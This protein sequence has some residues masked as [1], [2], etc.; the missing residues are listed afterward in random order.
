MAVW[1]LSE[2]YV[3][4]DN[5]ER[6]GQRVETVGGDQSIVGNLV[7][8]ETEETRQQS[9]RGLSAIVLGSTIGSQKLRREQVPEQERIASIKDL[10]TI[11]V[12]DEGQVVRDL[13]DD[14]ISNELANL[15]SRHSNLAELS[16]VGT[17]LG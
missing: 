6:T 11:L 17:T 7:H 3:E 1:S 8:G 14:G 16:G 9:C 15:R 10:W 13:A 12:V 4:D 5:N 2:E